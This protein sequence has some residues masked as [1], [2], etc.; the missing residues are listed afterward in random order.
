MSDRAL[1]NLRIVA[2]L[3]GTS[4]LVLLGVAMP[5]KYVWQR[6]EAVRVVGGLHGILF[7]AFVAALLQVMLVRRWSLARAAWAFV[8]SL[9]PAG[10][11]LLDRS[12]RREQ[13][14]AAAEQGNDAARSR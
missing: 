14:E 12:L 11:F 1:R 9:L 13:A 10:T 3:E 2:F 6:P 5:L 8:A 7:V 4:Y